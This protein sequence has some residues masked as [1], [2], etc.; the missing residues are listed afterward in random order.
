[1]GGVIDIAATAS[2]QAP[3]ETVIFLHGRGQDPGTVHQV[4]DAFPSARIVAPSGG[5]VLR[6][7]TTWFENESIGVAR[8]DSVEQAEGRFLDW[9]DGYLG[10]DLP[11]WL[12]GFSN[13]G[14]FAGHLLMRHPARF[15]GAALLS[16][17]LVLP[18]WEPDAVRGKSVFYGRGVRDGMVPRATFEAA[19]TYLDEAS[20]ARVMRRLYDCA[21]EIDAH[22]VHDLTKW[23]TACR[24]MRATP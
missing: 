5:V 22:E 4:A 17:P 6:R 3:S 9:L 24:S 14:A 12:C 8:R 1:V 15:A 23:F 7:G 16:A 13:G 21:H 11:P 10:A 2:L 19:E 18:P 20:G